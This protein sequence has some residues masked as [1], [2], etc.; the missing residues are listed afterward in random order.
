MLGREDTNMTTADR[1][2]QSIE[3]LPASLQVEALDFIEYLL[4]KAEQREASEWSALSLTFAMRDVK[5]EDEPTYAP[6]DLK[7]TFS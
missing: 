1:I 6:A 3:K 7:V 4:I 2:Q 5:G